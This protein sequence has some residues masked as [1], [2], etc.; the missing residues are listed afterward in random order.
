MMP[1]TFITYEVPAGKPMV[2]KINDHVVTDKKHRSAIEAAYKA[3]GAADKA[4][5]AAHDQLA[6]VLEAWWAS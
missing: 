5:R 4:A 3:A 6:V 2:M 1:S